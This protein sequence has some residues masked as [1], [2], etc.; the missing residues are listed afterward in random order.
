MTISIL[1]S[2]FSGCP[3]DNSL[4]SMITILRSP[5]RRHPP[6]SIR[7]HQTHTWRQSSFSTLHSQNTHM[8]TVS[9]LNSP[10]SDYPHEGSL[11]SQLAILKALAWRQ[12]PFSSCHSQ[13][14]QTKK[15]S[16]LNFPF[17]CSPRED[18]L[19]SQFSIRH[20]QATR[21]KTALFLRLLALR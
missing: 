9:I 5:M 11:Y 17:A 21:A 14:V 20:S 15:V 19:H 18:S 7:H 8:K 4:H 1:N 12:S 10:F 13:I 2:P 3:C 16:I 6:L